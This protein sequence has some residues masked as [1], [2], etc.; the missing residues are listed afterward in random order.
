MRAN[1]MVKT[2]VVHEERDS[3]EGDEQLDRDNG[4]DFADK[5]CV[6]NEWRE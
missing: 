5:S 3:A 2:R 4:I 6:G 1:E